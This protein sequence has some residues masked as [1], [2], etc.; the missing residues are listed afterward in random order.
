MNKSDF[1][2]RKT[3]IEDVPVLALIEQ[4]AAQIFRQIPSLSWI[5]D[6]TV[7]P[8]DIHLSA[9]TA[10]TSWVAVD[11][12]GQPVAF[13]CA[14]IYAHEFHILEMSVCKKEQK[15]GIG[16][17]LLYT[18]CSWAKAYQLSAVTL[19]TFR[20][21]PWNT[22]FY[23]RLGFKILPESLINPRL[24]AV[25]QDEVESGFPPQT[26]CAMQLNLSHFNAA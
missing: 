15:R 14:R 7:L 8:V 10:G 21:L 18:A 13:L 17:A 24:A 1:T 6:H 20:E 11:N 16:T 9:I 3:C 2:I 4:S 23:T 22:P 26:R 5:A 12:N 19:T 25:L